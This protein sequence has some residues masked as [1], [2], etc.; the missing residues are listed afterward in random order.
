MTLQS[1]SNALYPILQF[2][3]TS[4]CFNGTLLSHLYSRQNAYSPILNNDDGNSTLVSDVHPL[5]HLFP[6]DVTPS[7]IVIVE[8]FVSENA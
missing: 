4:T 8:I 1:S 7:G 6:I 2:F 3:G 5:K